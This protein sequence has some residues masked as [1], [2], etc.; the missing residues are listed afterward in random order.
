MK[1]SK[2]IFSVAVTLNREDLAIKPI[3]PTKDGETVAIVQRE[4]GKWKQLAAMK[5]EEFDMIAAEVD[6]FRGK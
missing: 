6:K 3:E 5:Q 2:G 1:I 4:N